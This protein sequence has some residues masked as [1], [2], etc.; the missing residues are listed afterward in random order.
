MSIANL[1]QGGVKTEQNLVCNDLEVTGDL[2]VDGSIT[3]NDLQVNGNLTVQGTST[4]E[5]TTI[6]ESNVIIGDGVSVANFQ[7]SSINITA[8]TDILLDDNE[9][10]ALTIKDPNTDFIIIDSNLN[11]VTMPQQLEVDGIT[12]LNNTLNVNGVSNLDG[13][14]TVTTGSLIVSLGD[15]SSTSGQ[16][17]A[18]FSTSV[19]SLAFIIEKKDTHIWSSGQTPGANPLILPLNSSH[20]GYVLKFNYFSQSQNTSNFLMARVNNSSQAVYST[21]SVQNGTGT[22]INNSN[23]TEWQFINNKATNNK[24]GNGTFELNM[25]KTFTNSCSIIGTYGS[26]TPGNNNTDVYSLAASYNDS[27]GTAIT[28]LTIDVTDTLHT[29]WEIQYTLYRYN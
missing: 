28:N 11:K 2:T 10:N 22:F 16:V 15:I 13:A 27:S 18:D 19:G 14:T 8:D 12:T 5:G 26:Q 6:M 9:S 7:V 29:G 1:Y 4:L 24:I 3:F 25:V 23:Q 21:R 17:F 20:I